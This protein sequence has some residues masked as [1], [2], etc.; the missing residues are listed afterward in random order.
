ME[1]TYLG[2]DP[3]TAGFLTAMFPNGNFEFC[4][5]DICDDLDIHRFIKSVKERSWEVSAVLEDVHAIFN[6]SA[7]ST[8]NFGE[9]KGILKGLL[10]AN[11]IPYTLIQPKTWQQEIWINQDMIVSYKTVIRGDKE[12]KQKVVDTKST[13][14]N[15]AR[16]LFPHI[17]LRKNE[18]CKVIDDN[19]V[20][21][22]L[23]AEYA[24]RK[25]L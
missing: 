10:I 6:A 11:E 18:R 3:G 22:L 7:K 1:K 14:I 4:S 16:R 17:D 13:S 2:L 9:I 5:I 23:M 21:S 24:R 12:I 25:N 15:A 20:D 8:F 19:K